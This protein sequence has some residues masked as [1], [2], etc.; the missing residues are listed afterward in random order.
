MRANPALRAQLKKPML[1]LLLAYPCF[2]G[3]GSLGIL[4]LFRLAPETFRALP[5]L[6][7]AGTVGLLLLFWIVLSGPVFYVF[8]LFASFPL[9]ERISAE[10]ERLSRGGVPLVKPSLSE[11]VLDGG[12]RFC[13]FVVVLV[14]SLILGLLGFGLISPILF[15]ILCLLD[16]SASVFSRRRIFLAGQIRLVFRCRGWWAVAMMGGLI[17]LLPLINLLFLPYLVVISTLLC[18]PQFDPKAPLVRVTSNLD[19]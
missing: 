11:R 16:S 8:V 14:I 13:L 2:V 9:W 1:W 6:G 18:L 17:S 12:M 10:V 19:A 15:G 7:R 5:L 4:E 3:V